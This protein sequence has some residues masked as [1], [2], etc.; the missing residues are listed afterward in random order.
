MS[1]NK[2]LKVNTA[3]LQSKTIAITGSTGGLSKVLIN[4]LAKLGANFVFINQNKEKTEKQIKEITTLYPSIKIDFIECDLTNFD[5]VKTA[6]KQLKLMNIDILYLSA[7]AYN[8]TRFKTDIGYDN[9]FQIN[10]VSHYYMVKELLPT[11]NKN[12]GKVVAVGSIAHNYTTFNEDDIDFT[13]SEKSSHIYGNSK[14]FLMFSL[15]ELFENQNAKLC[16]VHPGVTLTNITNHYPKAINWLVKLA[17]KLIFPSNR[18]A[19]LSLIKGS[20]DNT[21][22]HYWIGPKIATVWGYPTK[23]KLNTCSE[24]ESKKLFE[25]AENIYKKLKD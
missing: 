7:G 4:E 12:N 3:S 14:R 16:V 23:T 2:W 5:A 10:F 1:I 21:D 20:F 17:M 24:E 15:Y 11:L 6:T 13:K 22:Y 8:I 25:I 18:K 19:S 9:V